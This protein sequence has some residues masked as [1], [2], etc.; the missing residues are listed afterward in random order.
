MSARRRRAR[1]VVLV[2]RIHTTN[3]SYVPLVYVV[4]I[5][6]VTVA[7]RSLL[8]LVIEQSAHFWA[9]VMDNISVPGNY[10][11]QGVQYSP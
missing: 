4:V 1:C 7:Q 8:H 11:A 10:G 5:I 9:T 3:I 6:F 2:V